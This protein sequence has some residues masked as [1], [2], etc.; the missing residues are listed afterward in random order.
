MSGQDHNSK[1]SIIIL[2]WNRL[3]DTIECLESVRK[4]DYP[5]YEVIL[6]DNGSTDDSPEKLK[7]LFPEVI[8][9]QNKENLGFTG[10]NNIGMKRALKNGAD[11]VWLLNNDTVVEPDTLNKLVDAGESNPKIGLLSP[12]IYHHSDPSKI[13]FCG[14]YFDFNSFSVTRFK[15]LLEYESNKT[16]DISLWGTALLIKSEVIKKIGLLN[17]RY[18][19]YWE[20]VDYSFRSLKAGY[21]NN[22]VSDASISHKLDIIKGT[23]IRKSLYWFYYM[24]RNEFWFFRDNIHFSKRLAFFKKYIS[25]LI[26]DISIMKKHSYI[27]AIDAYFD[28]FYCALHNIGGRWDKRT[29][30]IPQV[31]RYIMFKHPYLCLDI[32]EGNLLK[33]LK[34]MFKRAKYSLVINKN[35]VKS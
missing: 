35:Y 3:K 6:V 23:K 2:N 7:G 28:G 18:F 13:Q 10:G 26:N 22:V 8:L 15:D 11:Y 21:V 16:K 12:V 19:A 20:D 30:K 32:L 17:E 5:N 24:T 34:E 1:V 25:R 14:S 4:M 31:I 33:I 27:E 9:I 29:K